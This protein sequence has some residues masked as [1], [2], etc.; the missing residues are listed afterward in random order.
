MDIIGNKIVL[1]DEW[2]D[3][4]RG[5]LGDDNRW[6]IEVRI[7]DFIAPEK[8]RLIEPWRFPIFS[9]IKNAAPL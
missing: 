8:E 6:G 7:V 5:G 9:G 2:T 4:N 3:A 1:I